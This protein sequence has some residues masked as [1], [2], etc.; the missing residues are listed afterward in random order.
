MAP[1]PRGRSARVPRLF[2]QVLGRRRTP[3]PA[4][5]PAPEAQPAGSAEERIARLE[6]R[7]D[8]LERLLEGLQDSVHRE[9]ARREDAIETLNRRTDPA[10]M[11][12]ELS[13]YERE[14][15]L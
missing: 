12:R 15:G 6:A 4:E 3:P 7:I 2:E 8:H 14:H 13:R 9:G 1:D 11:A 10:A 5:A